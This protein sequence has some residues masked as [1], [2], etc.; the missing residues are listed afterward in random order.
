MSRSHNF[1]KVEGSRA[2]KSVEELTN[3]HAPYIDEETEAALKS[4]PAILYEDCAGVADAVVAADDA[5]ALRGTIKNVMY[6]V[7][8]ILVGCSWCY[9]FTSGY[10]KEIVLKFVNAL[11]QIN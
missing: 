9:L 6:F 1:G 3:E 7:F 8:M 4:R 10:L 11:M 5:K 2:I